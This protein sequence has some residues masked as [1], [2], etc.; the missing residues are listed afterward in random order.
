MHDCCGRIQVWVLMMQ[1]LFE[2][3]KFL[4][5]GDTRVLHV[6][7]AS[8]LGE[9]GGIECN[10]YQESQQHDT[11]AVELCEGGVQAR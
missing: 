3:G 2:C 8:A 7:N 11:I 1:L 6:T 9:D 10:G 4:P 5:L